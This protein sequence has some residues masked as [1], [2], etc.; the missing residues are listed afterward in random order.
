MESF[1]LNEDQ[2]PFLPVN[3]ELFTVNEEVVRAN[4]PD[5]IYHR[6]LDTMTTTHWTIREVEVEVVSHK[7]ELGTGGFGEVHKVCPSTILTDF[8]DVRPQH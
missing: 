2:G 3:D 7:G 1:M 4:E 5:P 6:R 8:Q